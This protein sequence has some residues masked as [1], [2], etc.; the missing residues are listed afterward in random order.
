[1]WTGKLSG[2]KQF[3]AVVS[4]DYFSYREGGYKRLA[5]II[6]SGNHIIMIVP[7][8]FEVLAMPY[9]FY[10]TIGI[11]CPVDAEN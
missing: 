11:Y 2:A 1:L 8:R 3:S 9:S 10:T 7:Q 5:E 6:A 4:N